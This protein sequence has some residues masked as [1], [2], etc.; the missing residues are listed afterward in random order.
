MYLYATYVWR[1]TFSK[2]AELSLKATSY[3]LDKYIYELF[4]PW[5][6]TSKYVFYGLLKMRNNLFKVCLE[7]KIYKRQAGQR[8]MINHFSSAFI[9]LQFFLIFLSCPFFW[10]NEWFAA[11]HYSE[12][13][14]PSLLG[15]LTP[16]YN[17][18]STFTL[19]PLSRCSHF[20]KWLFL[21]NSQQNSFYIYGDIFHKSKL[22][23]TLEVR[24]KQ[25]V[26]KKICP[27]PWRYGI[28]RVETTGL[29]HAPCPKNSVWSCLI[30]KS[31]IF[32]LVKTSAIPS[33]LLSIF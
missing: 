16:F 12:W 3:K 8:Q 21:D 23:A 4:T 30:S 2:D 18:R 11:S 33:H 14:F 6:Y 19:L 31:S 28:P 15:C 1:W 27:R 9:S 7:R 22:S 25:R 24:E 32:N 26:C 13:C 5:R 29:G 10:D 17:E 20:L